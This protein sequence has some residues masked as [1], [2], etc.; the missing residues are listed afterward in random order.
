MKKFRVAPKSKV[1]ASKRSAVTAANNYGWVVE[2]WEAW[3]AY[4]GRE[5]E[6]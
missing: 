6:E 1:T 4:K 5:T 3:D 2:N